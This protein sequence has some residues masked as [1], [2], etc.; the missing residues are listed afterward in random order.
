MA[1][2]KAFGKTVNSA[3][4]SESRRDAKDKKDSPLNFGWGDALDYAQY[5]LTA[6]GMVPGLGNVADLANVAVSGG[7]AAY[8]KATGDE[9]GVKK[10]L[11]AGALNAAAAIPGAGLAVGGTKLAKA[12]LTAAKGAK[13]IDKMADGA[14]LVKK[15]IETK[16]KAKTALD[17]AKGLATKGKDY[18]KKGL[19]EPGELL[20]KGKKAY[21]EGGFKGV[22]VDAVKG[23]AEYYGK[24]G[25]KKG[26]AKAVGKAELKTEKELVKGKVKK[27]IKYA[28]D[29]KKSKKS[30]QAGASL[31]SA[32][33]VADKNKTKK[34]SKA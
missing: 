28:H 14:K 23:T 15:G 5:G 9:A 24:D 21:K 16:T 25:V 12:G 3:G 33:G 13:T 4:K 31:A 34:E 26:V 2:N 27:E 17:T 32:V 30:L 1:Y 19:K 6:A 8:A 22:G 18:V 10:H 11:A 29:K 7:R 20:A